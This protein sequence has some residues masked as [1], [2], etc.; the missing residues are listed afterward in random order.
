MSLPPVSPF[1]NRILS[2]CDQTLAMTREIPR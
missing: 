1:L 2:R